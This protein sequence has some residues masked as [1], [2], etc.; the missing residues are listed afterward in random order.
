LALLPEE[1]AETQQAHIAVHAALLLSQTEQPVQANARGSCALLL[2]M[3]LS[4][5]SASRS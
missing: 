3:L 5:Q 1:V 4:W 2:C